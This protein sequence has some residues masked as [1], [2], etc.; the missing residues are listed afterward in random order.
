M[1][2]KMPFVLC[3]PE[4][5]YFFVRDGFILMNVVHENTFVVNS[6]RY[7]TFIFKNA[8]LNGDQ[9]NYQRYFGNLVPFFRV[10]PERALIQAEFNISVCIHKIEN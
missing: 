1:H 10:S 5:D 8:D 4:S 9:N 6:L 7:G 3:H 2:F